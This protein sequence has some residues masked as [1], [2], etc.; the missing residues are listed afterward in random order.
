MSGR[1]GRAEIT[2][3]ARAVRSAGGDPPDHRWTR[4]SPSRWRFCPL[5]P[6]T[7]RFRVQPPG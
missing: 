1:S 4:S 5:D 7:F 2:P 3:L 6:L